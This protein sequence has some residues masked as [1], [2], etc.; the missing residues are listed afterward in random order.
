[1][2]CCV[3]FRVVSDFQLHVQSAFTPVTFLVMLSAYATLECYLRTVC[4]ETMTANGSVPAPFL[5]VSSSMKRYDWC[6][7][8]WLHHAGRMNKLSPLNTANI[9]ICVCVS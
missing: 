2:Q 9:F 7:Q 6:C 5:I 3:V 4:A 1:M 8:C